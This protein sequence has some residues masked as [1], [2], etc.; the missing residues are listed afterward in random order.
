M[1]SLTVLDGVEQD[2][3]IRGLSFESRLCHLVADPFPQVLGACF[4]TCKVEI[5]TV[6][7]SQSCCENPMRKVRSLAETL[8]HS[9][10]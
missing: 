8:A 4:L 5:I 2:F 7:I 10:Y 1:S 6:A 3:D 9:K